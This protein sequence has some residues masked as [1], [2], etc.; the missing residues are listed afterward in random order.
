VERVDGLTL[1]VRA[2]VV[3]PQPERMP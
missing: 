1:Y 2:T 3:A